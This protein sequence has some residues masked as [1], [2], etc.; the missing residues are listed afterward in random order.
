LGL[1]VSAECRPPNNCRGTAFSD[2]LHWGRNENRGD[3]AVNKKR[4]KGEDGLLLALVQGF[5]VAKAAK[6]AGVGQTTAFNRLRDPE[7]RTRL[8]ELRN[9]YVQ[10]AAAKLAASANMSVTTLC[11]LQGTDFPPAVRLGAAKAVLEHMLK[12][13]DSAIL[14]QRLAEMEHRLAALTA[15]AGGPAP[16]AAA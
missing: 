15:T 6:L 1:A 7:F 10:R 4:Y 11:R 13:R 2:I 14:E 16:D 9:Q 3:H 12:F 8:D 5:S